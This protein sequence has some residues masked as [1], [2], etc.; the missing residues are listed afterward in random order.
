MDAKFF[1]LEKKKKQCVKFTNISIVSMIIRFDN[2]QNGLLLFHF[3]YS[4]SFI[5]SFISSQKKI[6][7]T[8]KFS[9]DGQC[10]IVCESNKV[11]MMIAWEMK[12]REEKI[13]RKVVITLLFLFFFL[14]ASSIEF[15]SKKKKKE[16][17]NTIFCFLLF[18]YKFFFGIYHDDDDDWNKFWIFFSI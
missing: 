11:M 14:L 13:P 4:V 1:C 5:F 2:A 18:E 17:Y 16:R 7:S 15:L 9:H 10:L 6:S 3:F 12:F 8:F